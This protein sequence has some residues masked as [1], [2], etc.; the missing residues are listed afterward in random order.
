MADLPLTLFDLGV[1][2]VLILS[3]VVALSRGLVREVVGLA[4]WIGAAIVAWYA[5]GPVRQLAREAIGTELIAD[6][7]AGAGVFFVPLI[8]FKIFGGILAGGVETIGLGGLDRLLGVV[9]GVARGALLVCLAWLVF[10]ALAGTDPPPAWA[11]SAYLYEP[12]ERGADYLRQLLPEE[13]AAEG[14]AAAERAGQG[15]RQLDTVREV[16]GTPRE[17]KPGEP[18]YSDDQRRA[19]DQ[20]FK[21]DG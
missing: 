4:S 7:L 18:G 19:M 20:L 1:V 12:V 15:A 21:P 13:L 2:V 14:R 8:L 3:T 5:F 11:R 10:G 9:F 17:P 16:L 6:L